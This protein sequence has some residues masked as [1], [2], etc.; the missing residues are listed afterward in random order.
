MPTLL[1]D[2][3]WAR[4]RA[5]FRSRLS[6]LID[7]HYCAKQKILFSLVGAMLGVAVGELA[8]HVKQS[9]DEEGGTLDSEAI[10]DKIIDL[11]EKSFRFDEFGYATDRERAV[12]EYGILKIMLKLRLECALNIVEKLSLGI[13]SIV[14]YR[15]RIKAKKESLVKVDKWGDVD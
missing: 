2:S 12:A 13:E 10:A 3:E 6:T 15:E 5:G 8:Q 14:E 11:V 4:D 1:T 9:A 7:S